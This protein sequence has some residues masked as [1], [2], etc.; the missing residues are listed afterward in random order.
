MLSLWHTFVKDEVSWTQCPRLAWNL[1]SFITSCLRAGVSLLVRWH[2][3]NPGYRVSME[4]LPLR[5][6]LVHWRMTAPNSNV[7]GCPGIGSVLLRIT[8][9][10][11]FLCLLGSISRMP[12]AEL[13]WKCIFCDTCWFIDAWGLPNAMSRA[14]LSRMP[15]T[16]LAWNFCH[17]DTRWCIDAWCL[18]NNVEGWPGIGAVLFRIAYEKAFL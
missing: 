11:T 8:Y 3:P 5:H 18:R 6:T 17:C 16:E 15:G 9:E 13:M 10:K 14:G 2:L 1:F 12:G 7:Q 4:M